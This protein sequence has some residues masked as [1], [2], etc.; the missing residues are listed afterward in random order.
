[1]S[2]VLAVDNYMAV[3]VLELLGIEQPTQ[4]QI[5]LMESVVSSV[6]IKTA[7]FFSKGLTQR[8]RS[9]LYWS[10]KGKTSE[11]IAKLLKIKKIT[12]DGHKKET[13]RKLQCSNITQCVYEGIKHGYLPGKMQAM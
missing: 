10:A 7:V 1:M 9:C 3:E 8:E 4:S 13:I 6:T 2:N 12:V 11:Q 5:D